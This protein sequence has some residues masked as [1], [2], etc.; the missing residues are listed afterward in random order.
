MESFEYSETTAL[1]PNQLT[2]QARELLMRECFGETVV[3]A[4]TPRFWPVWRHSIFSMV[5]VGSIVVIA[6]VSL[7]V[8][9]AI[10]EYDS[11]K[12][13]HFVAYMISIIIIFTLSIPCGVYSLW[14]YYRTY[15]A[16]TPDEILIN[17]VR[18]NIIHAPQ[19]DISLPPAFAAEQIGLTHAL[20]HRRS[21]LAGS[22]SSECDT[23]MSRTSRL[24]ATSC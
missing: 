7:C 4:C 1:L 20:S 24:T 21:F 11:S 18:A 14:Q 16:L 6:I 2:P 13:F 23:R 22:V 17:V 19:I 12:H 9:F 8:F 5:G 3:Y 10:E 15:F